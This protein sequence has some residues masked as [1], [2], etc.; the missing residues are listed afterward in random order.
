MFIDWV[1]VLRRRTTLLAEK[2]INAGHGGTRGQR[3]FPVR[4]RTSERAVDP[5]T[6]GDL[7]RAAVRANPRIRSLLMPGFPTSRGIRAGCEF[8]F[9]LMGTN[10]LKPTI[11]S[12][13]PLAWETRD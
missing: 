13:I 10:A 6:I 3:L 9:R 1:V 4:F 12:P 11:K 8:S 7:L 2:N 5:Q